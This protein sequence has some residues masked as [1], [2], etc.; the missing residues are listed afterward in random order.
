[1]ITEKQTYKE[2]I[3]NLKGIC[4]LID[5]S[6]MA[7]TGDDVQGAEEALRFISH[8]LYETITT[9]TIYEDRL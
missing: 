2:C 5:A 6:S 1:M 7:T 3:D 8:S 4:Y 9:L